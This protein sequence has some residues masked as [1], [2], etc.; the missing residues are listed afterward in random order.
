M[1]FHL[2]KPLHGWREFFGEVGIIVVGVLIALGAEQIVESVHWRGEVEA[3]RRSLLQEA[4]DTLDGV[5]LRRRQQ[6]CVDHRLGEIRTALARHRRGEAVSLTG[7][8]GFPIVQGAS[9]GSWQIALAGQALS[10]MDHDE[11]L[12]FSDVFGAFDLWDRV[13]EQ[14]RQTWYRLSMLNTPELLTDQDW[15]SAAIAYNEAVMRNEHVRL[16]AP[17]V[18]GKRLPGLDAYHTAPDDLS[19]F[20]HMAAEICQPALAATP[21]PP[22]AQARQPHS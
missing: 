1:H 11:R 3:E 5:A 15:G 13:R 14:E 4:T 12:A 7:R 10:H 22:P 19:A 21:T 2:P 17:F 20:R 18:L 9:R 16:L 6:G 8:I